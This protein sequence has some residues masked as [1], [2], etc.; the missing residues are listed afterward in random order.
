MDRPE[1]LFRGTPRKDVDLFVPKETV[2]FI[3][4]KVVSASSERIVATKFIVPTENLPVALGAIKDMHYYLCADEQA[5]RRA[6]R[7]GAIYTL[8][9]VGFTYSPEVGYAAWTN[10]NPVRPLSKEEI[11]S[12]LKAMISAGVY[13]YFV[14]PEI[15]VQFKQQ[16]DLRFQLLQSLTPLNTSP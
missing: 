7:G 6:D 1:F 9:S 3:P 16:K 2:S 5:F 10:P 14:Y 15:L 8:P 12:A 4:T 13:V 11:P